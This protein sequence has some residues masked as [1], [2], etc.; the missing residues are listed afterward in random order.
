ML[1][2]LKK[3]YNITRAFPVGFFLILKITELN[4]LWLSILFPPLNE[5]QTSSISNSSVASGCSG[6]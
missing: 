3:Q 4:I 6:D 5:V 1:N 2:I